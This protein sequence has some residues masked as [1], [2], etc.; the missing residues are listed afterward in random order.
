MSGDTALVKSQ[1]D[2][3]DGGIQTGSASVFVRSGS[4]WSLQA[5]WSAGD[6][7][8]SDAFGYSVA[9][10]GGTALIGAYDDATPLGADAGSAYVLVRTGNIWSLQAKLVASVTSHLFGGSVALNGDTALVGS[11]HDDTAKRS[12]V[13]SAYVF[14]RSGTT[15]SQQAKLTADDGGTDDVFG[16]SVALSGNTALVGAYGDDTAA[17]G[18]AGSAYVFVRNGSIWSQQA[19]LFASDGAASDYFGYSVGLSGDTAL[20][21]AY[22][23]GK[24]GIVDAG[25]AYVFVRIGTTW[26][27]QAGSAYV[28]T[29]SGSTWTEQAKLTAN[30][31][32]A[33]DNFGSTVALSGDTALVEA[34]LDNT[35]AGAD[36]GSAYVF[37]LGVVLLPKI[38]VEQPTGNTLATGARLVLFGNALAATSAPL[39]TFTIRNSGNANLTGIGV[40]RDG[41]HSPSFL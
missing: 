31:G 38:L 27:E 28:F 9:L 8:A 26:S 6:G 29:R 30:D 36:A 21:G 12:Q 4:S 34:H 1:L 16:W 2:V 23:D 3:T 11:H 7:A 10:S 39:R 35:I 17:G 41:A 15:W 20:I 14:V 13:G 32:A 19:H 22:G 25:S 37:R 24:S 18:D 40:Q 33:S 5:Q